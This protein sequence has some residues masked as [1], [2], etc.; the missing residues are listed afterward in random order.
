ML[1]PTPH[2]KKYSNGAKKDKIGIKKRFHPVSRTLKT[3]MEFANT[4]I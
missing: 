3:R 2:R 1:I 4:E